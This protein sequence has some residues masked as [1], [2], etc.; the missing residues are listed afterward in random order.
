MEVLRVE[1]VTQGGVGFASGEGGEKAVE[2]LHVGDVA[3]DAQDR[4][5]GGV[6]KR[7]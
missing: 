6:G 2:V 1:G 3:T 4:G 7:A 5:W